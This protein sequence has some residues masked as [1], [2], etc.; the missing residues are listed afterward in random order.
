M[1][2]N[3]AVAVIGA[4]ILLGVF[5]MHFSKRTGWPLTLALLIIGLLI[6]P[7]FHLINVQEF[8][9]MV[10][11]FAIIALII[12]LF[13]TGYEIKL[14]RIR[15]SIFES[16]GLALIGV[17]STIAVVFLVGKYLLGF[18]DNL[19]ILFGALLASTDLTVIVPLM[20]NMKLKEN[21]KEALDLEAT[22]NSVFA[23]IIAIIVGTMILY[24]TKLIEAISKG[25]VYHVLSGI[26]IGLALGWILLKGLH[27]MSFED[28]PAIVTI[29]AV[30]FVYSIAELVGASGV[31][32]ALIVGILYGNIKPAPPKFVMLF[33][34]NLQII[35]VTFVYILLGAM[36]TF[37]AFV[38]H[39][40][41]VAVL[42]TAIIIVRYFVVKFVTLEESLLA[43]RVIGIAGPRGIISAVLILSYAYLFPNPNLVISLG[44]AV[45]LCTSLVVFLLPIIEKRTDKKIKSAGFRL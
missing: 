1:D 22:L 26:V 4:V 24:N 42:V 38:S 43:Q 3:I 31:L 23:A 2:P 40:L 25:L 33:G 45:I 19:A 6:G 16:T 13:D 36:I 28:M 34:E 39:A 12:V 37:D 21:V 11:S 7:V 17:L 9:G 10:Q 5:L 44:L 8:Q 27:K 18:S 15:Q 32:A 30:L 29:G 41:I 35:L 14:S 20:Q